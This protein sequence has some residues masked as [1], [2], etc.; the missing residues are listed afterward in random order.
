[1]RADE[2]QQVAMMIRNAIEPLDYYNDR[3]RGEEMA[4][5]RAEGLLAMS[6]EDADS[7]LL[8]RSGEDLLGFCLSRYDDGV[9]WLSWFGVAEAHRGKGIGRLLLDALAATLPKRRSHKI[10]CDTRTNN[11]RSQRVLTE[12]GF[13]QIARIDNHWYGQDFFLWEWYPTSSG[14]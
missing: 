12:A 3:A 5:Y 13:R 6:H 8:A 9:V 1:M 2:A 14:S 7:I 11:V 4:K 10:W